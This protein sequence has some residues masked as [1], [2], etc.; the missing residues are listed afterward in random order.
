M[1]KIR[2]VSAVKSEVAVLQEPKGLDF[3]KWGEGFFAYIEERKKRHERGFAG[4]DLLP[5]R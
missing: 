1:T 5:G 3:V 4:I 2:N